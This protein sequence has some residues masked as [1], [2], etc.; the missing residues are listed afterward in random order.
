MVRTS[1]QDTK[2]ARYCLIKRR[3][4]QGVHA[5]RLRVK[6]LSVEG[7][8]A[9]RPLPC[10]GLARPLSQRAGLLFGTGNGTELDSAEPHGT[11]YKHKADC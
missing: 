6:M 8:R 9:A 11:E 3:A 10:T 5:D 2:S 1:R 7:G 4:C